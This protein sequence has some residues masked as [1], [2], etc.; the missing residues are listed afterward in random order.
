MF[1]LSSIRSMM[2]YTCWDL[3][4]T[5]LCSKSREN[6]HLFIIYISCFVCEFFFIFKFLYVEWCRLKSLT[7]MCCQWSF[8]SKL[9]S[10]FKIAMMFSLTASLYTL[11]MHKHLNWLYSV[12]W[13][14]KIIRFL[15]YVWTVQSAQFSYKLM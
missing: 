6:C 5:E 4:V 3:Y 11:W 2:L 15:L 9:F 10:Y 8:F 13:I 14:F 12:Y 1:K 7:I